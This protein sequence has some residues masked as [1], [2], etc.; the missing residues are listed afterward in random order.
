MQHKYATHHMCC[1]ST[2]SA[3]N[4]AANG[5]K[6]LGSTS[7]EQWGK[8]FLENSAIG[9]AVIE[10][11]DGFLMVNR[12]YEKLTGYTEAELRELTPVDVTDDAD[13][14]ATRELLSQ[15]AREAGQNHTIKKRYRR[16]DGEP[17]L[18]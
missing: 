13:R 9:M 6:S 2:E 17:D 12:A 10:P 3:L 11:S 8:L 4:D 15:V 14:P 16:K 7:R 5:G 1:A 18:G